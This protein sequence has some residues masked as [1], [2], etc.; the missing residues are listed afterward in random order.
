MNEG[1]IFPRHTTTIDLPVYPYIPRFYLREGKKVIDVSRRVV[2]TVNASLRL[3]AELH[4]IAE[5]S[6]KIMCPVKFYYPDNKYTRAGVVRLLHQNFWEFI[7]SYCYTLEKLGLRVHPN[8][9]ELLDTYDIQEE[10][11]K[12]DTAYRKYTRWKTR[13]EQRKSP[14]FV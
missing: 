5:N 1:L 11:L 4:L 2:L 14:L 3:P 13:Q 6:N 9:R 10:H 7:Y 12:L 8:L